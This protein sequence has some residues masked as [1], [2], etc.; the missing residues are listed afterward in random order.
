MP[1]CRQLRSAAGNARSLPEQVRRWRALIDVEGAGYSGRLKL[2]LHS[3][4]PVLIQ[5]RPWHEWFWD[6]LVPW[7]NFIPV[8]RDLS[9]LVSRARWV[10]ENPRQAVRIGRAGQQLT[11]RLLTRRSAVEQWARTLSEAARTPTR[12]WAPP[13][14]LAALTPVLS[15]FGVPRE[16][17]LV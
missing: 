15:R 10:K 16:A 14:L 17:S 11:Q 13:A 3:G 4:R 2:L 1:S 6:E 8:A 7:E 9:D 12:A 5:D